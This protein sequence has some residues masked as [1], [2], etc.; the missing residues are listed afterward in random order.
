MIA[1][2]SARLGIAWPGVVV[3]LDYGGALHVG[4]DADT[5]AAGG[6]QPRGP[7]DEL[8]STRG[9]LARGVGERRSLAHVPTSVALRFK[10]EIALAEIDRV[11]IAGVWGASGRLSLH[12]LASTTDPA[13]DGTSRAAR[14]PTCHVAVAMSKL[15]RRGLAAAA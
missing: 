5:G 2:T 11:R 9:A 3:T 8:S 1:R 14:H 6:R 7:I 4:V 12:C 13:S 15:T 10:S